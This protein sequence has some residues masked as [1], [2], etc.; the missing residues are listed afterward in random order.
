MLLQLLL[1]VV[2]RCWFE[3]DS[4]WFEMDSQ[5]LGEGDNGLFLLNISDS[6]QNRANRCRRVLTPPTNFWG[7]QYSPC[8]LL[9]L[10]S[11][12]NKKSKRSEGGWFWIFKRQFW[13][14][15]RFL[16]GRTEVEWDR[17][18]QI[19]N[20]RRQQLPTCLAVDASTD[21]SRTLTGLPA[22]S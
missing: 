3:L 4:H 18:L 22:I 15:N 21:R 5:P 10:Q 20:V 11:Q 1:F 6:T 16:R 2:Q 7:M 9:H 17:R 12:K 8:T 14:Y 13:S 19:R